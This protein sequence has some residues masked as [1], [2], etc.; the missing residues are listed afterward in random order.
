MRHTEDEPHQL[1]NKRKKTKTMNP[2]DAL[3]A[4]LQFAQEQVKAG[5]SALANPDIQPDVAERVRKAVQHWNL[6]A[7]KLQTEINNQ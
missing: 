2:Q 6:E 4:R 5:Q 3:L 7:E 1:M